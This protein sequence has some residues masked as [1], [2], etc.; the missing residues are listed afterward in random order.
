MTVASSLC[1]V[2]VP[3]ENVEIVALSAPGDF[4]YSPRGMQRMM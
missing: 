1:P 3:V 2:V 4:V